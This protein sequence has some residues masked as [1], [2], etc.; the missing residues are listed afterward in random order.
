MVNVPAQELFTE[1]R[2]LLREQNEVVPHLV[3]EEHVGID[4]QPRGVLVHTCPR[5]SPEP[6][7]YFREQGR[8]FPKGQTKQLL[9]AEDDF[10]APIGEGFSERAWRSPPR[11]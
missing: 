9:E 11:S 2:V 4:G 7:T 8:G 10:V 6:P 3:H 1:E 5:Q